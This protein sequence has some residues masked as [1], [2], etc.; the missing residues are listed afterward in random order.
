[1][2]VLH[3]RL[4]LSK[5][6]ISYLESYVQIQQVLPHK[7]I[8]IKSEVVWRWA[9]IQLWDKVPY[10]Y[11]QESQRSHADEFWVLLK[12]ALAGQHNL[13]NLD[14]KFAG[15]ILALFVIMMWSQQLLCQFVTSWINLLANGWISLAC[16]V[17]WWSSHP[18]WAGRQKHSNAAKAGARAASAQLCLP[19]DSER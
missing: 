19:L 14:A 16:Q 5:F 3:G 6:A 15:V 17:S 1:M 13:G 7:D 11:Q 8:Q 12:C 9:V 10:R 18:L 2:S 4:M